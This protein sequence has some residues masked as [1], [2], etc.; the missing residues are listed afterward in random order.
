VIVGD[1]V[2]K[3]GAHAKTRVLAIPTKIATHTA[4]P[5]LTPE[6]FIEQSTVSAAKMIHKPELGTLDEG[7]D[8]DVALFETDKG[9]L[10]CVLTVRHGAVVWDAEGLATTDWA[11]AGPYTNFK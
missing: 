4:Q 11:A 9:R 6:A 7:S 1:T 5:D 8:A 3:L 2:P 10:K